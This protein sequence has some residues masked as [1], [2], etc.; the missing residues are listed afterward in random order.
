ML[1]QTN[2]RSYLRQDVLVERC[3]HG[4]HL[5]SQDALAL[6]GK[7]LENVALNP[8]QHER[9]ELLVQRLDLRL[10]FGIVQVKLVRQSD[11]CISYQTLTPRPVD[12]KTYIFPAS[13]NASA[14]AAL[15]DK[16]REWEMRGCSF[17][18]APFTLFWSGVPVMRSFDAAANA[19]KAS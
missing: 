5:N 9:L 4:G 16:L 8:A 18:N 11:C 15:K 7:G 19:R 17:L 12:K 3:L 14:R 6:R 1:N 13:R 10:M 2:G